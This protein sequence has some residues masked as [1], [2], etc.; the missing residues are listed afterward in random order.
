M[1]Q[2][3]V[4]KHIVLV[5]RDY[6]Y[7]CIRFYYMDSLDYLANVIAPL[8]S[9]TPCNYLVHC[10]YHKILLLVVLY[11]VANTSRS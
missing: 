2:S 7:Y 9:I 11:Q 6:C 4:L 5:R 8:E 3:D 1:N 10:I